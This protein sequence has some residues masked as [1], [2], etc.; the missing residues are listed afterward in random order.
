MDYYVKSEGKEL[1]FNLPAGWNVLWHRETPPVPGV[2]DPLAD[3]TRAL[4][5]PIGSPRLEELAKPG[6]EVALLFDDLQRPTP[7]HFVIPQMLNRLNRAGVPDERVWGIGALG[8]HPVYSRRELEQKVGAEVAARL[9]NRLVSH[10]PHSAENVVI[11]KTRRGT[12]VEI[13]QHVAFA[14]LI[15]AVG[16]CM[17]HP[18]A[19]F[20]GGFKIVM[21]GVCSYR[22]V[23]DHHFNWMRHRYSRVNIL[24]GNPW[25][26]EIVD[27]GRLARLSFK[28]DCIVNEK[29]EVVRAFAG[30]P[31]AEHQEASKYAASL[32]YAPLP[33]MA[34]VTVTAAYPLEIGVQATKALTMAGFCTR[35][36]GTIIWVAPQKQAGPIMPLVKEMASDETAN[37]FHRRLSRGDIPEH[38]RSFGISY[39]MQVVFFKEMAEKFKVIHVTEGLS[40]AQVEMMKFSHAASVQEA[41][42]LAAASTK[43]ANV[44]IFPAGGNVIPGVR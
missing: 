10:D 2:A 9:G 14:D 7:V 24:E 18:A 22:S 40:P 27:A 23:A 3:I 17:P 19:G 13:N 4:E 12:V 11:G 36:A 30:D 25:Y 20:G 29:K 34:D 6:M 28:L 5:E 8:T 15:I 1:R 37:E 38:L 39:I 26:E 16:E 41:I 35:S 33:A 21:P 42:D 44:V 31:L 32:Y 43:E